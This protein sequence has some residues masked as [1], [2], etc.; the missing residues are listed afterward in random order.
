MLVDRGSVTELLIAYRDGD[1][2]A[3]D[4]AFELVYQELR[5][6]SRFHLRG[7]SSNTL[8]TT[9]LV[10]ELYLKLAAGQ[11]HTLADRGHLLALSSRA[12]R[13]I[14]VDHARTKCAQKRGGGA[15]PVTLEER[16][17][18]IDNE[19]EWILTLDQALNDIRETDER[20]EHVIECRYFAGLTEEESAVA[21]DVSVSTV[22]RDWRR[23][24]AWLREK[25]D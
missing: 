6:L 19:A 25:L 12:M 9:A 5:K 15:M 10:H 24:K 4:Q 21:L 14:I 8:N 22:Q 3:W 16:H 2:G 1:S 20:L 23:A 7:Q 13:Q 18:A 11:S 17:I